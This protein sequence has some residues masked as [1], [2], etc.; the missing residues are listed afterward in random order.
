MKNQGMCYLYEEKSVNGMVRGVVREMREIENPSGAREGEFIGDFLIFFENQGDW[1][2][3][4]VLLKWS[5]VQ[6]DL[7]QEIYQEYYL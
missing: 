5:C 6:K 3:R 4:D 1:R 7:P 2:D